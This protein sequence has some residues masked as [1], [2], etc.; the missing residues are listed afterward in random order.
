MAQM[1]T[2]EGVTLAQTARAILFQSHYWE[3]PM[4]LPT[5]Q[6]EVEVTFDE[7]LETVIKVKSWL[8]SKRGFHEFN[9]YTDEEIKKMGE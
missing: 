8:C 4:W 9:H 5:S 3:A 7:P 2:F 1:S 6:I